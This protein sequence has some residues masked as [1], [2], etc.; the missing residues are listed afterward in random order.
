MDHGDNIQKDEIIHEIYCLS[1]KFNMELSEITKLLF[2]KGKIKKR[3]GSLTQEAEIW[4]RMRVRLIFS[5]LDS[6]CHQIKIFSKM[7]HEKG[8]ISLNKERLKFI[9]GKDQSQK[10]NFKN[11]IEIY[12]EIL[13]GEKLNLTND[14]YIW[15]EIGKIIYIRNR[16]T[17]PESCKDY[18][19]LNSELMLVDKF[20]N[21]FFFKLWPPLPPLRE[22]F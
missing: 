18:S 7:L 15:P 9:E 16:I 14:N 4:A 8:K 21:W 19:L 17:H 13:W 10:Q 20:S 1:Q 6:I 5:F 11:A 3:D 2:S 12:Y 22:K